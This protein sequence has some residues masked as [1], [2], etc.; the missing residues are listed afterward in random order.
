VLQWSSGEV[1]VAPPAG[2]LVGE[3][4]HLR[5]SAPSLSWF[6]MASLGRSGATTTTPMSGE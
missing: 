6:V 5:V 4:V 2:L 1:V 3:H